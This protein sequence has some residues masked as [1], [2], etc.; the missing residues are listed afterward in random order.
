M[1]QIQKSHGE[2]INIFFSLSILQLKSL[3]EQK[4]FQHVVLI[5]VPKLKAIT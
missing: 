3:L 4:Q 5:F 1:Q 2:V